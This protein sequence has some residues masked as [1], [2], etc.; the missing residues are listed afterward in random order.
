MWFSAAVAHLLQGLRCS[1][2]SFGSNKLSFEFYQVKAVWPFSNKK[3]FPQR[4]TNDG[5][6]SFSDHFLVNNHNPSYVMVVW[7]NQFLNY[8][9]QQPYHAHKN[10]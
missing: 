10:L 4:T 3:Y 6:F 5:Y 8:S 9:D 1:S 2:A 7:E